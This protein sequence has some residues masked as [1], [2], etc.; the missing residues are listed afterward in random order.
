[1]HTLRD[2][3]PEDAEAIARLHVEIWR[4]TYRAFAPRAIF[5]RLNVPARVRQWERLL[6]P[7]TDGRGTLVTQADSVLTAF[8]HYG[9]PDDPVFGDLGEVKKL[10][11]AEAFARRGIGRR[12]LA[13][14]AER[15]RCQGYPGVGVGVLA[16]N[17]QARAFYEAYGGKLIASYVDP[18]PNWRSNN[19]V[20][21]WHGFAAF[22]LLS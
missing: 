14:T 18:G 2:A 15:L 9:P 19:V 10:Y 8:S 4:T 1:M 5:E 21:A 11:V 16:E 7:A 13:A 6:A 22:G 12:L 3:C 20:Y 17:R